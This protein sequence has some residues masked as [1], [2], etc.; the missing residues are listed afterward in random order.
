MTTKRLKSFMV[1]GL[2]DSDPVE[3]NGNLYEPANAVLTAQLAATTKAL[4]AADADRRELADALYDLVYN[5][6]DDACR[7]DHLGY[8]QNHR[9]DLPCS[10][11]VYR[12][13]LARIRGV[14][15]DGS[16]IYKQARHDYTPSSDLLGSP[17]A[18]C[19][20]RPDDHY[21]FAEERA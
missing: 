8:C 9:I 4:E 21:E 2:G 11:A 7:L 13:L 1:S 12:A 5:N 6:W 19:R 16:V 18:I 15:P 10:V 20:D 17:C 14:A 3:I